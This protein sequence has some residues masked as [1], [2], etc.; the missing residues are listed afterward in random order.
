MRQAVTEPSRFAYNVKRAVRSQVEA[1]RLRLSGSAK[2]SQPPESGPAPSDRAAPC[3]TDHPLVAEFAAL[4][5]HRPDALTVEDI[6][7][8][9][10]AAV[11][12]QRMFRH[13]DVIQCY[14]TD[15]I[16]ALL[17]DQRPY[18]AFE[19]GTLRAFTMDDLPLHRLTAL[20][21]RKADHVF[22]TNG[23]C[24]AYA[25]RLNI[26]AYSPMI[27][28]IDV[29]QHRRDY[30][31]AVAA[32]RREIDADIVLFCPTRHD[33]DI[34]GTDR[35]IRALPLIK[36]RIPGRVKL[37][38]V[39]WGLQV[40]DS[41]ALIQELGCSEDVVWR[42]T[43]SRIPMI[44]HIHAA[45]VVFDQMVLPVFG[46]TA[47]QAIAAG[48]PVV[49]SYLPEQTQWIIPEPAPTLCAHNLEEIADSV[50]KALEPEWLADYEY[51]ARRWIDLYHH[52]RRLISAHL[53]V[54]SDLIE[55]F[56]E[57]KSASADRVYSDAVE[58]QT[59]VAAR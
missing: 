2:A 22:I 49:A 38:L 58:S 46:A 43:M 30:G 55:Q 44:K 19:H 5:P 32:L 33:W 51:R 39:R 36:Q 8:Y 3:D 24:L 54:Y 27:H 42:A 57:G 40:A 28:P 16:F 1:A 20:S 15:P 45:D 47:P 11:H 48:K 21:Y 12:F 7:P 18:V 14:A 35:F 37:V 25:K 13:Y 56:R 26:E 4:F 50:V 6:V 23:D 41:E 9:R 17:A 53:S 29:E 59:P 10:S 52:P 34:K 31:D